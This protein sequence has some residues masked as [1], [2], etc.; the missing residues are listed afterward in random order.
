MMSKLTACLVP[1]IALALLCLSRPQAHDETLVARQVTVDTA[2]TDLFLGTDADGGVGDWYLSNGIVQAVIDNISFQ[3][4]VLQA[5]GQLLPLQNEVAA[6]GGTLIDLG[7]VGHN[8]DQLDSMFQVVNFSQGNPILYVPASVAL[9]NPSL[10]PVVA[11]VDQATETASLTVFGFVLFGPSTPATPTIPVVTEYSLHSGENFL[12]VKTIVT[13]RAGAPVEIFS[14]TDAIVMANRG[15]LPFAVYPDRG[16]NHPALDISNPTPAIGIFPYVGVIGRVSPE[17]GIVD[18]TAMVPAG[19]V[20]YTVLSPE[21]PVIIGVNS[22]L[23]SATGNLPQGSIP[24]GESLSY[25]RRIIVGDR[26]DIASGS[27]S[28]LEQLSPSFGFSMGQVSGQLVDPNGLPFRASSEVFQLDLDPSTPEPE[29][30]VSLITGDAGP[31]PLTHIKTDSLLNGRF[32]ARLP[33]GRYRLKVNAEERAEIPE[34]EFLVKPDQT[35][36]VGQI[37]LSSVGKL[38]FEVSTPTNLLGIPAK[39][40]IKGRNRTPD[41]TFGIPLSVSIGGNPILTQSQHSSAALNVVY[42]ADG[43]GEVTIRPGE[44]RVYASRGME[45]DI[46][47]KDVAIR[48]GETEQVHLN[49]RPVVNSSGYLSGDFHIHGVK[50]PDSSVPPV[51]RVLSFAAEGV[52]VMV[53]TDHDFLFDYQPV[54]EELGLQ[55][56]IT[57]MVGDEVTSALPLGPFDTGVGHFAGWPLRISP[58]A[59]KDG[60]PED[61]FV[62]PN[63]IY[64]RLRRIGA[65][66]VQLNHAESP[67]NGF[68]RLL[69]FDPFRPVDESPNNILL[70]PSILGTG[71]RNIDYDVMEI[72]NGESIPAYRLLRLSWFSLLNQGIMKAG[73]AVTD[74]H[75]VTLTNS[76]FPRTFVVSSS[77]D[78]SQFNSTEFNDNLKVM[79]AF[80]SSGPFLDVQA[81]G[82]N[83]FV[84]PGGMVSA[85]SR[86]VTLRVRVQAPSWIPVEE[87]RIYGNGHLL[88]RIPV[89]SSGD[90][91]LRYDAAI[92]VTTLRDTYFVVEAGQA[93]PEDPRQQPPSKGLMAIIEPGVASLAFSNPVFVDVDG[94]GAF[95]PPGLDPFISRLARSE[96]RILKQAVPG[97]DRHF[98]GEWRRFNIAPEALRQFMKSTEKGRP[99]H[100]LNWTH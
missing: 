13:N 98:D 5:T 7:L 16:F 22:D 31:L 30:L 64:D 52:D 2:A 70:R 49:I 55:H 44:Y 47:F 19:E 58:N 51:D 26:N 82:E 69:G 93:L 94:N 84:G 59:R 27:D 17:D 74:T 61:E 89:S 15:D 25:D 35:T 48:P 73:T 20:S 60:A 85:R 63:V 37:Q 76:G 28:A 11:R 65:E 18:T 54:I 1:G 6:T 66:V 40:T 32:Q 81:A 34:I 12:R 99:G 97:T 46:D 62:E 92:G 79:K 14:V 42:T 77:T 78:M 88:T 50:S 75:L 68:L 86:L 38:V 43:R 9:R 36:D 71:T 67:N 57:A 39:I 23:V 4:D 3:S 95:D 33:S 21:S 8:N 90:S 10:P 100:L 53:S 87:V 29:T 45:Y 24:P 96:R 41:P 56:L 83:G 80:G 91:A 72:Y